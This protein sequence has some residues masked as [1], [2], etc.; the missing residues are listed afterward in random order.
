MEEDIEEKKIE[1]EKDVGKHILLNNY[2]LSSMS[3]SFIN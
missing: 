2:D 1:I 3:Q